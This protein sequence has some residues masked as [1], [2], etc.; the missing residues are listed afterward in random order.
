MQFKTAVALCGPFNFSGHRQPISP[1]LMLCPQSHPNLV[2][3]KPMEVTLPHY[4]TYLEEGD[5]EKYDITFAKADHTSN[6]FNFQPLKN[7]SADVQIRFKIS[8]DEDQRYGILRST[9]CCCV[10]ITTYGI[11]QSLHRERTLK[12]GYCL[13]R[14]EIPLEN[15]PRTVQI[16]FFVT[17]MLRTCLEVYI[18]NMQ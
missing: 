12:A 14:V 1:I 8:K 3:R 5:Y 17:F 7:E 10:C 4:L 13:S 6:G 9:H 18:L 15:Y 16:T 11:N 2:L